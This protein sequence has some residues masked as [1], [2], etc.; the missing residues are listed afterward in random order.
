MYYLGD[1]SQ[2]GYQ[3]GKGVIFVQ[4]EY[5]FYG[6]FD[7]VP[8]GH[9]VLESFSSRYVYEGN[10]QY[11]K[12]EGQGK[13]HSIDNLFS[14]EGIFNHKSQPSTG[15]LIVNNSEDDSKSYTVILNNYPENKARIVYREG[16]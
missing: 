5:A 15:N 3:Q 4:D 14:F 10:F 8:H 1:W 11:G 13:V 16:R 6:D 7:T 9:G 12:I 2:A